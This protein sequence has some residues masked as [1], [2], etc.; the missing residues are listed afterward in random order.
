MEI[1]III[2]FYNK[3]DQTISCVN[4]FLSSG[5]RIYI[6]NNG[7]DVAQ[8]NKLKNTFEGISHVFILDAG[9]NLGV[10]G[11]RNYLLEKTNSPW[12]FSVDNDIV[13]QNNIG[14]IDDLESFC[15]LNPEVKIITPN[16]FN[17]HES[18][19][20][21][22]INVKIEN[23]KLTLVT[24]DFPVSNCFPGGA[25]IVHR[26]IFENYGLFD[27]D[28]FVGF[29]D[30]EFALRALL[31]TKGPLEVY[32][33]D[34][35]KLIHDHQFQKKN[36][37]KIAVRERYNEVR[38]KASYECLVNKYNIAFDHDWHWWTTNQ[39]AIMTTPK[40]ILRIKQ[41]ISNI[42]NR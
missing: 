30:Y 37:D 3:V 29:E 40:L 1:D 38:M 17:V 16:L 39:L 11:G 27:E 20:S 36:K 6:L 8:L 24:G 9:K 32:A 5:Q 22:Q 35:I 4:S 10:S 23:N 42:L 41:K 31:S 28:M 7:S 26:S 25:V 13:V 19:Y 18:D 15:S 34:N 33:F 21:P 14:W 2:L 12:I